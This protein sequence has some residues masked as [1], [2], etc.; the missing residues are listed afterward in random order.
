MRRLASVKCCLTHRMINNSTKAAR[1]EKIEEFYK[2]VFNLGS[3]RMTLANCGLAVVGRHFHDPCDD[4]VFAM[5]CLLLPAVKQAKP[6]LVSP[7]SE[8]MWLLSSPRQLLETV[9]QLRMQTA[10]P[11]PRETPSS[12]STTTAQQQYEDL[13]GP[14]IDEQERLA[15]CA[16]V[17][18]TVDGDVLLAALKRTESRRGS[19][20]EFTNM[21]DKKR[22][23]SRA[24]AAALRKRVDCRLAESAV[25]VL[26]SLL[27]ETRA[28]MQEKKRQAR[29]QI[30]WC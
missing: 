13:C 6:M 21:E 30:E 12:R 25:E 24:Y 16:A 2:L 20:A 1:I 29:E 7:Y 17:L 8:W 11:G 10:K 5:Q 22:F 26:V 19:V 15:R 23:D 3:N 28:Q 27:P 9:V 18:A 14:L 4:A